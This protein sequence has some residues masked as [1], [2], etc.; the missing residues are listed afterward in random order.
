MERAKLGLV[1]IGCAATALAGGSA[2]MAFVAAGAYYRGVQQ[3]EQQALHQ[4]LCRQAA[5]GQA[6]AW[7]QWSEAA[8]G[9][10]TALERERADLLETA[11]MARLRVDGNREVQARMA[12]DEVDERLQSERADQGAAELVVRNLATLAELEPGDAAGQAAVLRIIDAALERVD[13]SDAA[14]DGL[15]S[16]REVLAQTCRS[17]GLAEL[18]Q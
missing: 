18:M 13:P 5:D 10:V 14:R 16:G 12:A 15:V 6:A 1:A 7:T 3:A 8:S 9:Q 11:E 2:V 17:P 4:E